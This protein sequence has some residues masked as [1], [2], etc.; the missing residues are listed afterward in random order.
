MIKLNKRN[1]MIK[2]NTKEEVK[3]LF[4]KN[5]IF[6]GSWELEDYRDFTELVVPYIM[7][8]N[9]IEDIENNNI[10]CIIEIYKPIQ[11]QKSMEEDKYQ[12][13]KDKLIREF[14]LMTHYYEYDNKVLNNLINF[15]REDFKYKNSITETVKYDCSKV[16]LEYINKYKSIIEP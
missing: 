6:F 16:A 3:E 7:A 11:Q 8:H 2:L 9:S 12:E 1:S 15:N 13:I 10:K 4:T 5:N 14:K